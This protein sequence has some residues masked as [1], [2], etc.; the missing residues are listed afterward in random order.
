MREFTGLH[1]VNRQ[2]R[3]WPSEVANQ[4]QHRETPQRPLDRFQPAA[5][6]P[7]PVIPYDHRD[8]VEDEE[9]EQ[10]PTIPIQD[11]LFLFQL[12]VSVT[13][14]DLKC[15]RPTYLTAGGPGFLAMA[16]LRELLVSVSV[17]RSFDPLGIAG[18]RNKPV[19]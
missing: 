4:R 1:D 6:K 19:H 14:F 16:D 9:I 5:L 12:P 18:I 17:S 3:Q 13:V 15:D 8:R 2:V 10:D 7:P 11:D